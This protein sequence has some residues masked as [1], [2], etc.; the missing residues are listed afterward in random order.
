VFDVQPEPAILRRQR[1]QNFETGSDHFRSDP[2]CPYGSYLMYT[3]DV[4]C[5][6]FV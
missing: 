5:L 3:H 4:S 2:V 1:F 6:V